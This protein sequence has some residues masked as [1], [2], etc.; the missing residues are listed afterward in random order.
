MPFHPPASPVFLPPIAGLGPFT[1][2]EM[3]LS[4]VLLVLVVLLWNLTRH[5]ECRY[6]GSP[7]E[8]IGESLEA[9]AGSSQGH[10]TEGNG[11]QLIEDAAYFDAVVEAIGGA[12]SSVHLE[13]F[14][15]ADG[16][17]SRRVVGALLAAAGRGLQVRVL[18]DASGSSGF[19]TESAD[20]LRAAGCRFHRFHRYR[21]KNFG[22]FN[23]RDHRKILIIDGK[24]AI[25]GGHCITDQWLK[26]GDVLPCHRDISARIRG[27]VVAA[28]QSCFLENWTE[29]TGEL[30][31]DAKTFP[32]LEAAG[33][34]KGHVAYIKADRCPSSVQM[35]HHL[36]I[37][38]ADH[39]IR[40]QNPY[41]L[42][43][44]S[45]TRALANA[46]E[47][48]VDVRI[49]IPA[50]KAT[51]SPWVTRAGR[52]QF[53]RLLESGVRIF[54]YQKTLLHQKVISIDGVW[55][56]VG[57]SNFDDRSFEINDEITIG[58][59]DEAIAAELEGIF[60]KDARECIEI[61]LERW[62]KRSLV[63]RATDA[64]LYLFNEQL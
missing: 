11:F 6:C 39:R 17:A 20:R 9:L 60:E 49:M 21:L 24:L 44:P 25:V 1:D 41:F 62:R 4:A 5:H 34:S 63:E 3:I 14:L 59:A 48:G 55:S 26:D 58:I 45:G 31:T 50:L 30:F 16:E 10:L 53:Q 32:P 18:T 7:R 51:D 35:L 47:R 52:F 37:G 42:P 38:Y 15:W 27:P 12:E 2:L 22:R 43:D 23:I 13:T 57:S 36:C 46:A 19:S 56:G 29:V 28:I 64:V 54:E 61:T 33:P 40:I 8:G